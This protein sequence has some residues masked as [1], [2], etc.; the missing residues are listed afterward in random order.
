MKVEPE[1]GGRVV[2]FRGRFASLLKGSVVHLIHGKKDATIA[3]QHAQ[4]TAERLRA[5]NIDFKLDVAQDRGLWIQ[6][7]HDQPRPEAPAL[8]CA[9][10]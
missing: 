10:T 7:E 6:S 1:L 5:N 2:G 3:V 4:Y 9:A 8:F